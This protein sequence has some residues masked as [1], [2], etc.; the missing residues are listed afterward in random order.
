MNKL[1]AFDENHKRRIQE[2]LPRTGNNGNQPIDNTAGLR[3]TNREVHSQRPRREG[4]PA[5]EIEESRRNFFL[6]SIRRATYIA[7]VYYIYRSI[8]SESSGGPQPLHH[9]IISFHLLIPSLSAHFFLYQISYC[10]PMFLPKKSAAH[11][12][13]FRSH[14]CTCVTVTTYT[15]VACMVFCPSII[16]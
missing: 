10:K 11:R 1:N 15:L 9:R 8:V 3:R 14:E 12:Q 13:L 4:A 7:I 6:S 2:R 16:L 5:N